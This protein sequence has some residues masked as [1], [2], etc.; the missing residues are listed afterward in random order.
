MKIIA[1]IDGTRNSEAAVDCLIGM[2]LAPDTQIKLLT[3]LKAEETSIALSEAK[4]GANN[5]HTAARQALAD[6]V[7]V[8]EG[9]IPGCVISAE[10]LQGEPKSKIIEVARKWSCDLIVVGSRGKKGMDL[11]LL[12]SVSQ[13]ILMQSPC[14]VLIVKADE[15]VQIEK[16]RE[17][18]KRVLFTADNS[19]Y[20]KAAFEWLKKLRFSKNAEFRLV[21]VVPQLT[22]SFAGEERASSVNEVIRDHDELKARADMELQVLANELDDCFAGASIVTEVAEG[23]PREMILHCAEVWDADLIVMGSHGRSGLTKLLL[24]SVSQ[25]IAIHSNCAVAVVR[26]IAQKGRDEMKLTGRFAK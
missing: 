17:G 22:D 6:M 20:S 23:D 21:T 11:I 8:L 19:A 7:K 13:G 18:F 5:L 24:G 26:G 25:A 4:S 9:L 16:F 3:V 1:A 12:G 14:P 15:A 2:N 10:V